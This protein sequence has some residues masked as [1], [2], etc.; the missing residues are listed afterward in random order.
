MP[1]VIFFCWFKLADITYNPADFVMNVIQ[2]LP[3]QELDRLVA[4]LDTTTVK[5]D[6]ASVRVSAKPIASVV[7]DRA[8]SG[9]QTYIG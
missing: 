4:H 1:K 3:Q 9:Q 7:S 8:A 5:E 2:A 6:I